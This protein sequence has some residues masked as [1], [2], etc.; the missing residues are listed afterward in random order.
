MNS[1]EELARSWLRAWETRDLS[2]LRLDPD[3]VHSSP[4]GRIEGAEEYLRIVEPMSDKS[5]AAIHVR[6]VISEG[7]QAAIAYELETP[8]GRV[9]ACDW[10]HVAG[11]RIREVRS[12]YDPTINR[13]VLGESSYEGE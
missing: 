11:G 7:D 3:F 2:L 9:D 6:D 13:E 4:F 8:K 10:I 5:V 12:Y 1:A